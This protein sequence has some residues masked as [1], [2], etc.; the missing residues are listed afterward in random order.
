[1]QELHPIIFLYFIKAIININMVTSLTA[2]YGIWDG[3][4]PLRDSN[5]GM[6]NL[7]SIHP[8]VDN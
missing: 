1:M 5:A 3:R 8:D 7:Q 2:A 4:K 6:D